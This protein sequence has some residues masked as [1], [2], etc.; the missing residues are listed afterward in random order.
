MPT[1]LIN[2][3]DDKRRAEIAARLRNP[4]KLYAGCHYDQDIKLLLAIIDELQQP[5][6]V[7]GQLLLLGE[8]EQ[9]AIGA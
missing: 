6:W 9:E 8:T 5:R 3:L 7:Q 2:L 1:T 4:N